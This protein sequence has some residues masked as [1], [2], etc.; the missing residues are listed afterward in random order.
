[1]S[2]SDILVTWPKARTLESYLSACAEAEVDGKVVNFRVEREITIRGIKRRCY[3]VYDG[4]VRGWLEIIGCQW[5]EKDVVER[6]DSEGMWPSGWY[7]VCDPQ[8]HSIPDNH[9]LSMRGFQGWRWFDRELV[10]G[11]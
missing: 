10:G 7:I 8:W 2:A 4:R 9:Q 1:V 5:R 11:Y 3:R 6:V